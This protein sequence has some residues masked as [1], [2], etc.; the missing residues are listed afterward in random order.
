MGVD[1]LCYIWQNFGKTSGVSTSNRYLSLA[2]SSLFL[3]G[4]VHSFVKYFTKPIEAARDKNA[5]NYVM[6]EGEKANLE[7]KEKLSP[8]ILQRLKIDF[9]ADK[10]PTK[11][12]FVVWTHISEKQRSMYEKYVASGES[13]VAAVL[14]GEITS[15]LE[16]ITWLKKLCGHP[17][18]VDKERQGAIGMLDNCGADELIQQ[19]TKLH[20]LV[21]LITKLRHEGHRMLVFSQSTRMLDIIE[22]VL[23]KIKIF[24]VDGQTKEKDRQRFVDN[25]NRDDSKAQV[26]VSM[27]NFVVGRF[28]IFDWTALTICA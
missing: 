13:A 22:R 8:Y 5:T 7:L 11:S 10:L 20:V 24:R 12:D 1:G 4:A 27:R 15:P 17:I 19:S 26:M 18:L 25:F 14:A 21:S 16:A 23:C 6:R 9:L 28:W 3:I 2:I